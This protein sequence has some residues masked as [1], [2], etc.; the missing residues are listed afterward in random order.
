MLRGQGISATVRGR[1]SSSISLANLPR[2][3]CLALRYS[4]LAVVTVESSSIGIPIFWAKLSA[5]RVGRP[6]VSYAT[7]LGGPVTSLV[8]SGCLILN[9]SHE[10]ARRRGDP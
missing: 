9:V 7:D 10:A 4:P 1:T 5:A 3:T 6:E 2:I 8:S